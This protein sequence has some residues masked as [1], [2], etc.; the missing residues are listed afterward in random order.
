MS[1]TT[2]PVPRDEDL[3][4]AMLQARIP[5]SLLMDLATPDPHS[6]ELYAHEHADIAWAS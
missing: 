1:S 2:L 5:I 3:L 6:R 4:V